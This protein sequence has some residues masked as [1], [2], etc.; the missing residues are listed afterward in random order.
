MDFAEI[1]HEIVSEEAKFIPSLVAV[2]IILG[3]CVR[4][5]ARIVTGISREKT[6]REVSAYVAE[7]S[8]TPE[9]GERL[10]QAGQRRSC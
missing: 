7:G 6:R 8:M 10:L 2:T 1:M 5:V 9:H 4:A 3:M